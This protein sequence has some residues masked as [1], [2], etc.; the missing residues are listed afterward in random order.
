[1]RPECSCALR[2]EDG[3]PGRW[4]GPLSGVVLGGGPGA[5]ELC[6]VVEMKCCLFEL[7]T[8]GGAACLLWSPGDHPPVPRCGPVRGTFGNGPWTLPVLCGVGCP[9]GWQRGMGQLTASGH[10]AEF[11]VVNRT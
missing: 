3:D 6:G 4:W 8:Q 1:M 9:F 7:P 11:Q 5:G 2:L 10:C